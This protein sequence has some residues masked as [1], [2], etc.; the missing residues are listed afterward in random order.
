MGGGSTTNT[1]V[2]EQALPENQQQNVDAL[3]RGALQYFKSGGRTFY[4]GDLIADFT[5]E[6]LAGQQSMLDFAGGGGQDLV[7]QAI[8]GNAFF[9]DPNNIF[10]PQNV[11]GFKGSEEALTRGY[12]QNLTENILPYVRGGATSTGQFGGSPSGI[13]QALAVERSNKGLS[14]SLANLYL[15]AY[16]QGLDTFNQSLNRAPGLF[17]L[18]LAPGQ[19]QAGVGDVRQGQQQREIEADVARHEFQQNEPMLLLQLLQQLT[20]GAGQYGGTTTSTATEKT[21]SS[22]INQVLGGALSLASL[23][24]PTASLFAGLGGGGAGIGTP[25]ILP[26]AFGG[27]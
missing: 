1:Q 12:T 15:G 5:P 21:K 10:N 18:G 24:N 27:L 4:P 9:M 7:N 16:G 25:P 6:Q 11:P 3:L 26:G 22:P 2:T 20:G 13:G 19:V 8:A 23:W 17:G 14:D